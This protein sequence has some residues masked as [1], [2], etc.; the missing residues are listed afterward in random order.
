MD[1]S[2]A[3]SASGQDNE[4]APG[5]ILAASVLSGNPWTAVKLT[6][7]HYRCLV[8]HPAL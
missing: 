7:P 4:V 3:H 5:V 1:L 6:N 8:Q 2:T